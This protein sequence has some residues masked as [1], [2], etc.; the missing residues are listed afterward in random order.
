MNS[1]ESGAECGGSWI[2]D[3]G[4]GQERRA[5]VGRRA[6]VRGVIRVSERDRRA[7][8]SKRA[9]RGHPSSLAYCCCI[10]LAG[11]DVLVMHLQSPP[12]PDIASMP[13]REARV[14]ALLRHI[15]ELLKRP[16]CGRRLAVD[17]LASFNGSMRADDAYKCIG[18]VSMV[19]CGG[20]CG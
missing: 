3:R 16:G 5:P 1:Q 7:K 19:F 8:R 9:A 15:A 6:V 20:V 11:H 18:C 14:F 17:T 10:S 13:G 2:V 4:L 12:V